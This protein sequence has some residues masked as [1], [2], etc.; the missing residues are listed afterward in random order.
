MAVAMAVFALFALFFPL[1]GQVLPSNPTYQEWAA[2]RAE[3][4]FTSNF[5]AFFS[6]YNPYTFSKQ[7]KDLWEKTAK[8][9]NT[10]NN[11]MKA[12]GY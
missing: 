1:Q 7:K 6:E 4:Q 3:Y 9:F 10:L 12:L 11:E 5:N 2:W 8:D